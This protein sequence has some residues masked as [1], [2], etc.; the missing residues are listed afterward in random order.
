MKQLSC[1]YDRVI[2]KNIHDNNVH[3]SHNND[4]NRSKTINRNRLS[5]KKCEW[6]QSK[7]HKLKNCT[8]V[9]S[10][11]RSMYKCNYCDVEC[12]YEDRCLKRRNMKKKE[13][14]IKNMR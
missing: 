5:N 7:I 1:N 2:K 12:H 10:K 11:D 13:N 14:N 8:Y 4:K 3:M 9:K 6:C